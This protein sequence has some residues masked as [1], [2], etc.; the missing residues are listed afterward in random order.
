MSQHTRRDAPAVAMRTSGHND[1]MTG[2]GSPQRRSPRAARPGQGPRRAQGGRLR[3]DILRAVTRLLHRDGADALTMRAVAAEVG[4]T[5]T[6]LYL[7]FAD[8]TDLVW[9]A[10]ADEYATLAR[11]MGAADD[12]VRRAR[13]GTGPAGHARERLRAQL[14]AY[15]AFALRRP[16]VYRLMYETR[17]PA[18]DL[19][20]AVSHPSGMVTGSLR[21]AIGRCAEAGAVLGLPHHV[22]AQ[23]LWAHVHGLISLNH[24]LAISDA[25]ELVHAC[26]DEHLDALVTI[27]PEAG[28][29]SMRED[30][31]E[32]GASAAERMLRALSVHD[33]AGADD[34]TGRH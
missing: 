9:A 3:E 25:D 15:I 28:T 16:Q 6:S 24:G 11:E 29:P 32:Q 26:A 20:R 34:P 19:E 14:H 18:V 21:D 22:L 33:A 12:L 8:K 30:G 13:T 23:S 17:Q 1:R 2:P 7:H 5:P 4:V 27:A 31:G 10:L